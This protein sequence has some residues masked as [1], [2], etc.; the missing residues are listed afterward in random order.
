M[1]A[2]LKLLDRVLTIAEKA[3]EAVKRY[4]SEKKNKEDAEKIR[5]AFKEQD[6]EKLNATFS[7]NSD[8]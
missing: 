7:N 6:A 3:L 1:P 2:Y 8:K 4:Q 5:K